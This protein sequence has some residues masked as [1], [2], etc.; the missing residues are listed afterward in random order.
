[1][2]KFGHLAILK[3]FYNML[4]LYTASCG[5]YYSNVTIEMELIELHKIFTELSILFN[6]TEVLQIVLNHVASLC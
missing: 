1:M 5:F 4:Y 3:M 2:V 6:S